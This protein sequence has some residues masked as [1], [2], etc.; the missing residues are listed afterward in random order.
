MYA[1]Q[2]N[3]MLWGAEKSDS[4]IFGNG[5]KQGG[6]VSPY[7]FNVHMDDL[8]KKLNTTPVGCR[9]NNHNINQLFLPMILY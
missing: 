7:R 1:T 6:A 9:I 2:S 8:S 5:V 3:K 4:F